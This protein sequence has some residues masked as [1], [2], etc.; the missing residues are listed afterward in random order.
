MVLVATSTLERKEWN[1][2]NGYEDTVY[3]LKLIELEKVM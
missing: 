2:V 3:S 1:K